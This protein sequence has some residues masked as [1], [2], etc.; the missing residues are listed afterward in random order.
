MRL[1]TERVKVEL[2]T[3]RREQEEN[4]REREG[5]RATEKAAKQQQQAESI[6]EALK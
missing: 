3:L 2:D 5:N 4:A 1:E 6:A